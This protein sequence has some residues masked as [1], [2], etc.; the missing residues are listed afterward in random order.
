MTEPSGI[1]LQRSIALSDVAARIPGG[2]AGLTAAE[3]GAIIDLIESAQLIIQSAQGVLAA[4]AG[5][6]DRRSSGSGDASLARRLGWKTA[7]GVIAAKAGISVGEAARAVDV[8]GAI[9][10]RVAGSGEDLTPERPH[11]AAA[12]L[13]GSLPLQIAKLIDETIDKV[14]WHLERDDVDVL[15]HGLVEQFRSGRFSVAKFIAHCAELVAQFDPKSAAQRDQAL[16]KKASIHE[17]WMADGT[18]RIVVVLDPE[19]AAFYRAA[20]NARTN[21]R[22]AARPGEP[23][24]GG[25]KQP[26][27]M[28]ARLE[29]FVSI[30]RD[31]IRVDEGKQAGV[32]TTILVRIDMNS[33]LSG[34]GSATVDG[35]ATPISASAARRLAADAD[36][37]PQVLDGKSQVLDQG[38][39]KRVFT[40]AQ[41]YAILAAFVGCAF[42]QCDI[43]SSMVEFHHL[44]QW[45]K[46]HDHGA[47]TDLRNGLPLCGFH[48]RLM[49]EGW[50]IRMDDEGVPWFIPPATVD[51]SRRPIRGGNLTGK[52]AA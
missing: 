52:R 26:T 20:V 35:V 45:A 40:K 17:T 15:E 12:V 7:R 4:A 23:A 38:E 27:A 8:G 42:P 33:L 48:N 51:W 16:R 13:G 31:S 49:E 44:G 41:R 36:I 22:R 18:L 11:V 32:D 14:A 28:E 1:V 29:A 30:M 50:E 21:P 6:L 47:G 25:A 37:I 46:R 5:E 39:S 24:R 34:I 43:P 2:I 9:R 19:R 3:D 10:P